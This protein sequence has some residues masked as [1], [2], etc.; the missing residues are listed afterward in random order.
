MVGADD[1]GASFARPR[2]HGEAEARPSRSNEWRPNDVQQGAID[3]VPLVDAIVT[4]ELPVEQAI[5][6]G[7][8]RRCVTRLGVKD[9]GRA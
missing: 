9:V 6:R 4:P 8:G 1:R 5:S 7:G 2:R 3:Q